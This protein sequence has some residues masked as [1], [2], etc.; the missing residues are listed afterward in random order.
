[1]NPSAFKAPA[2]LVVALVL[3]A[4]TLVLTGLSGFLIYQLAVDRPDSIASM[5]G[6]ALI[7]VAATA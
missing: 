6:L 4:E 2:V 7:T 5:V 3:P 1:M